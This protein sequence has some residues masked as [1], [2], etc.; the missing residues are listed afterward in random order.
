MSGFKRT[1]MFALALFASMLTSQSASADASR[2]RVAIEQ[3]GTTVPVVD[4]KVTL[5]KAPFVIVTTLNE[6]LGVSVVASTSNELVKPARKQ[7][8]GEPFTNLFKAV[9]LED[10]NAGETL[11]LAE[12]PEEEYAYYFFRSPDRYSFNEVQ[13]SGSQL[14]GKVRVSK[15]YARGPAAAIADFAGQDLYLVFATTEDA[16]GKMKVTASDYLQIHFQP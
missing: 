1:S 9:P 4:N 14:V 7:R 12:N 2:L 3:D 11:F 5:R 13:L 8:L 6:V 16:R 10:K 15:L